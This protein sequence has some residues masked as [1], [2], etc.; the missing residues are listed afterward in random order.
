VVAVD[1][2]GDGNVDLISAN[3]YVGTSTLTVFTNNG[4]GVF[5]SNA[6]LN[7]VFNTTLTSLCAA[8]IFGNGKQAL[9]LIGTNSAGLNALTIFTNN[10]SGGFG[11]HATLTNAVGS[12]PVS[13]CAADVNGDGHVD[14]ITANYG[15]NTLTVLTNNGSGGF[16]SNAT[17]NVGSGPVSVC[18]A[19]LKGYTN[20]DCVDLISANYGAGTLTVWTNNG[21]GVFGS[22]ATFNAT[23]YGGTLKANLIPSV[24]R[25]CSGMASW[26]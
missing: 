17:L 13:V 15:A 5:G 11:L 4:T 20:G 1:V 14:L 9:I 18:A 23:P 10:S 25:M 8:D 19:N 3:L 21:S 16:G 22:N 2:N 24:R 12:Q 6:T 26:L 7:V